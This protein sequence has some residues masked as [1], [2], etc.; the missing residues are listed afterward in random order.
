MLLACAL[1]LTSVAA[2]SDPAG[3]AGGV[4]P[5]ESPELSYTDAFILGIVEGVTEYL[6]VS[7]TGHLIL[8]NRFLDLDHDVP[9]EDENGAVLWRIPPDP[10]NPSRPEGVAYLFS[11]AVNAYT[12]VI[13]AGA[14]LAVILLYWRR[15]A[16]VLAGLAGRNAEGLK[17]GRNLILS[18]LPAVVFG[19]LLEDWIDTYLFGP[20]PVVAALVAGAFLMLAAESWRKRRFTSREMPED[21]DLHELTPK[22]ALL[23]GLLQCLAMWPGTSRSMMTIVGGYLVGL[24]PP[25]A[26]EYSFLL[27]LITLSAAAAYKFL[28]QGALM[29]QVL[30]PGPVLLGCVV[31]CISAL[32]AVRWLVGY[33]SRH[34][35]ALFAGYRIVLAAVVSVVL[36][37]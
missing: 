28:K 36:F 3:A 11:D 2:R 24:S 18:F 29:L 4:I 31:A 16:G 15:L 19:L 10:V 27:G 7:S 35:L 23:V 22:Q 13:Q 6:P 33:L 34:G 20:G 5:A 8:A 1:A 14:I 37:G 17:L 30:E 12:I 32:L 26:A 25:R 9:L 21:A